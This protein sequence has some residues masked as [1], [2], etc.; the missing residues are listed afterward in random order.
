[1]ANILHRARAATGRLR[2]RLADICAVAALAVLSVV[3]APSHALIGAVDDVPA[4]TLL[5]PYFEVDLDNS[6]GVTTLINITNA[7]ATAVLAHVTIWTDLGVP[8]LSF[9][10][11]LTGYDVTAI[12][13]RDIIVNGTFPQDASAGQDPGNMRSPQGNF[14]QDINFASCNGALPKQPLNQQWAPPTTTTPYISSTES[15]QKELT[16]KPSTRQ[17]SIDP[18]SRI[19]CTGHDFNDRI[20]RGY[21]TVDTV[22]GCS[23]LMPTDAVYPAFITNQNVII[24]DYMIVNPSANQLHLGNAAHI[25]VGNGAGVSSPPNPPIAVGNYTFYGRYNNWQAVDQREPLAT[26]WAGMGS[27]G[28]TDAIV[29]RDTKT[30]SGPSTSYNCPASPGM[31]PTGVA[32]QPLTHEQLLAFDTQ[33]GATGPLGVFAYATGRYGL[34]SNAMPIPMTNKLGWVFANLNAPIAGV[35]QPANDPLAL[36]AFVTFSRRPEGGAL[37]SGGT[38]PA[39]YAT[40]GSVGYTF[41]TGLQPNHQPIN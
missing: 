14:S 36:Q 32:W 38:G 37:P 41:D 31:S 39:P 13:L 19:N 18:A 5:F 6:S 15:L 8:I 22:N 7:S 20:A 3:A 35:M 4:G 17:T 1:M 40:S 2:R 12:N 21:I 33:E 25:E 28:H 30:S 34:G 24:G 9:D 10:N 27:I 23:S 16:G 26:N 29:W 11:Y